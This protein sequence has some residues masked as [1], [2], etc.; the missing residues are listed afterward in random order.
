[1]TNL[2]NI[3]V[4]EEQAFRRAGKHGG[5][6]VS[7]LRERDSDI[8]D[9]CLYIRTNLKFEHPSLE[10]ATFNRYLQML[11]RRNIIGIQIVLD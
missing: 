3:L 6:L 10:I 1:M 4:I 5:I 2:K 9:N 8:K 11:R 7:I